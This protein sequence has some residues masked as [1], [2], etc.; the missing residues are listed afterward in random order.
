MAFNGAIYFSRAISDDS[1]PEASADRRPLRRQGL[2]ARRHRKIISAKRRVTEIPRGAK[3]LIWL[4]EIGL[5]LI[6]CRGA[7]ATRADRPK[8]YCVMLSKARKADDI[9]HSAF[10]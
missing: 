10:W 6:I 7:D 5:D 9:N 8:Y 3:A 4:R 2:T 1:E